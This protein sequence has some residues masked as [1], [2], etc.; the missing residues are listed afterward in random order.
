M[1]IIDSLKGRRSIYDINKNLPVKEEVVFDFIKE[2]TELVPDA[3]NMKSSRVVVVTKEKQD[4]LWDKIYEVFDGEVPREKIDS[5]KK[6]FGTILYFIDTSVVKG[7][8]EQFPL[9]AP[10]FFEWAKQSAGMLE[11]SIWSGLKELSIGASIQHYNPIIDKMVK[12]LFDIPENYELNAQMPFGG[13]NTEPSPKDKEDIS[14][15]VK[16]LN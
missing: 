4:L 10:K 15:R 16:F 5:F 3:F 1:K 12:E 9:Y 13:I 8:E 14:L 11:L 2:A 6:G 7:L